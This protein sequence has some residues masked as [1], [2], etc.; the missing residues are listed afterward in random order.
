MGRRQHGQRAVHQIESNP[1]VERRSRVVIAAIEAVEPVAEGRIHVGVDA[2]IN[3][4][5]GG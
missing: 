1:T 5:E 2:S 4:E 3:I